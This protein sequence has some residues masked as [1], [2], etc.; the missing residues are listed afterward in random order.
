MKMLK[1]W[2]FFFATIVAGIFYFTNAC[3][4]TRGIIVDMIYQV[5]QVNEMDVVEAI[6]NKVVVIFIDGFIIAK[7]VIISKKWLDVRHLFKFFMV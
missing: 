6:I 7:I 3:I 2:D 1:K 5:D 4:I